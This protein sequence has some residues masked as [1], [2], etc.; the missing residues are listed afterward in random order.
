VIEKYAGAS[1]SIIS[2]NIAWSTADN[3]EKGNIMPARQNRK[4]NQNKAL[5]Q[6]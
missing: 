2:Q 4:E 6:F 5:N 1:E 3:A